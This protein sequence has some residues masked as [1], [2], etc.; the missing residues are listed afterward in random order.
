M[1][2]AWGCSNDRKE[3]E[4]KTHKSYRQRERSF[5][6]KCIFIFM[7]ISLWWCAHRGR[8]GS[9]WENRQCLICYDM[10]TQ[11]DQWVQ[12]LRSA[13]SMPSG[14]QRVQHGVRASDTSHQNHG[15]KWS[16]FPIKSLL[17]TRGRICRRAIVF[18]ILT[19]SLLSPCFLGRA[20][21][22][23][24]W[25]IWKLQNGSATQISLNPTFVR[26]VA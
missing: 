7:T 10:D 19:S 8:A 6:H 24:L 3:E 5:T 22:N 25:F 20:K 17:T 18:N 15:R 11:L 12:I 13:C 21:I 1:A 16:V 2:V 4:R 9:L 23:V 26:E 14:S